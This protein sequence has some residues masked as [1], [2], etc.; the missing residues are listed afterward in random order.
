[1][2]SQDSREVVAAIREF[3]KQVD[4]LGNAVISAGQIIAKAISDGIE[5][6]RQLGPS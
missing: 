5:V 2:D 1:M 3:A 6:R 4:G